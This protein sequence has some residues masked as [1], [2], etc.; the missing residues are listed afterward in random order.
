MEDAVFGG[1]ESHDA[2]GL[3]FID[4]FLHAR[5]DGGETIGRLGMQQ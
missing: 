2:R 5:G 3:A 4:E 1:D